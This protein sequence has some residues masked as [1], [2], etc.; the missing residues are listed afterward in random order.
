MDLLYKLELTTS[1]AFL[2]EDEKRNL[3]KKLEKYKMFDNFIKSIYYN[4]L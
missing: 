1:Q 2:L 3:N 4:F